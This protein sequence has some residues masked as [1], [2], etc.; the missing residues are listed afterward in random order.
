MSWML[1][2]KV[3]RD[4]RWPLFFVALLLALS[5]IVRAKITDRITNELIPELT[6]Y[7][8]FDKLIDILFK[9]TGKLLE[10]LLGGDLIKLD[11][12]EHMQTIGFVDPGVL[13]LFCIWALGRASSALA[14]EIDRGTMELLLAQPLSRS[15]V[16][17]THLAVDLITVP[18]L[19]LAM[20]AGVA[21][22]VHFIGLSGIEL[23]PYLGAVANVVALVLAL[24]GMV[25]AISATGRSRSRVLSTGIG[26]VLVMFLLTFFGQL[27]EPLRP[28]RPFSL[29]F[30]YQPQRI[31]IENNWWVCL[32]A[33][34]A[35]AASGSLFVPG[36]AVLLAVATTGYATAWWV[37]TR[38]DLPAPL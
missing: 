6:K 30:Y 29:F 12:A 36:I 20:F 16:V 31:I 13:I 34:E 8:G 27:W 4:I 33:R 9:G 7:I 25:L 18:L 32:D 24:S 14:G 23:L 3:L 37:F 19:G 28:F 1:F 38:R 17:L 26:I 10:T 5:Q 2:R 15:K 35:S 22:G 21:A 11:R